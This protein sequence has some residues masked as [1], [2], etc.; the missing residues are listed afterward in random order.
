MEPLNSAEDGVVEQ[1]PGKVLVSP[2]NL[3]ENEELLET[4]ERT[5]NPTIIERI[6]L[7][8]KCGCKR[9]KIDRFFKNKRARNKVS[10]KRLASKNIGVY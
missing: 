1:D 10:P 4:W 8:E 5:R 6:E 2:S 3:N 7:A 9:A